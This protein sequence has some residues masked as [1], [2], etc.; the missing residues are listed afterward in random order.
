MPQFLSFHNIIVAHLDIF[1]C[2]M[3]PLEFFHHHS[4]VLRSPV[5]GYYRTAVWSFFLLHTLS[6][7][8][9]I[10][11]MRPIDHCE[12]ALLK[13][14]REDFIL[15]RSCFAYSKNLLFSISI[16]C[17]IC[18]VLKW[19]L[20]RR[21]YWL[22]RRTALTDRWVA[23]LVSLWFFCMLEAGIVLRLGALL[24]WFLLLL[25]QMVSSHSFETL[26]EL[27]LNPSQTG[28][29]GEGDRERDRDKR[30]RAGYGNRI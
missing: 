4:L 8:S 21:C 10:L 15:V 23:A 2:Y 13:R 28:R 29:E 26:L 1:C 19:R 30:W 9:S 14:G 25:P 12:L 24:L 5:P 22:G 6:Y 7:T 11:T 17:C 16:A 3:V 20:K 27:L 18:L